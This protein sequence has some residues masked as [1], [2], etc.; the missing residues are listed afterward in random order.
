MA[1][2][3]ASQLTL[4]LF[5]S[6][7]LGGSLGL[8]LGGSSLSFRDDD[9]HAASAVPE[10]MRVPA[11]NF[12]L[13]GDRGLA[14]GW[15]ARAADNLA[16]IKLLAVLEQDDRAATPVEQERLARFTGF[17]ASELANALFPLP[18]EDFRKGW[19]DLG[20]D[21]TAA[22][23]DGERAGLMRATQ[24]A[25]YTPEYIIRAM[26]T[27]L[28]GMGFAGG[29]VLE[30]GCGTGL[31]LALMPEKA[32]AK[33]SI[34]AIEM[35]PLTARIAGKLFPD[36]WV[37]SE[38]FTK[39]RISER[40]EL[41][42]GNP[43][44][45][46]RTVRADDAAG[47]L[48]LSL[49]DYFLARSIERLKPGG[50]GAF[51]TSRWTMDK[52]ATT[53][54][55]HIAAMADLVGAVRLPQA[56]MLADAGTEVV[57]D[58]LVFRKRLIGEESRGHEWLDV[59]DVPGSDE[60]E[61]LL[62]V[63]GYFLDQPEMVLGLHT[64]TTSPYGPTYTCRGVDGQD[65][66]QLLGR[67]LAIATIGTRFPLP[68]AA[69]AERGKSPRFIP[70]TVADGA[71]VREGSYLLFDNALHQMV[72]GVMTPVQVKSKGNKDGIFDK[73]A[74]I[75]RALIPIRDAVRAVLRAQEA[76]EPWGVHQTRLRAV[77]HQFTRQFGP[78]NR[79]LTTTREVDANAGRR[80]RLAA[81]LAGQRPDMDE[82]ELDA[83]AEADAADRADEDGGLDTA[84][85]LASL[86]P[87]R[88]SRPTSTSTLCHAAR[89]A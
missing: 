29:H 78:I 84:A 14:K 79:V 70:G 21:L 6:T 27:S 15:K 65:L 53:A 46:D 7:A 60:G 36:A 43:P 39:A 34:T 38:D 45:S 52:T 19:E 85:L 32:A 22:T 87:D 63:N 55:E 58:V 68:E 5:D 67:A 82:A 4:G 51:V 56:A 69:T 23:S 59:R 17:G 8:P 18:G 33:A 49:H 88:A 76:N 77:Y 3:S 12:R 35:D 40:F 80:R 75:V 47:K 86:V 24:Y 9:D 81:K 1:S 16:A 61:G 42:I 54:R 72:D 73:H 25:H 2:H 20:R 30:P 83:V 41:V 71:T 89:P 66:P 13:D 74:R 44:F 10:T 26:W 48:G 11:V 37:R 57:V 50:I 62:S 64:W 28:S 31:F